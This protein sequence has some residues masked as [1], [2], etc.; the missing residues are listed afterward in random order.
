MRRRNYAE[1]SFV[2]STKATCA[3]TWE[4]HK[5]TPA[6]VKWGHMNTKTIIFYFESIYPQTFYLILNECR[7]FLPRFGNRMWKRSQSSNIRAGRVVA[8]DCNARLLR[9]AQDS[10]KR[11]IPVWSHCQFRGISPFHEKPF[12]H[13][14]DLLLTEREA[15][16]DAKNAR[17]DSA[18]R[19][20]EDPACQLTFI[21]DDTSW[22]PVTMHNRRG[23][24]KRKK[25]KEK[26]REVNSVQWYSKNTMLTHQT[27]HEFRHELR[28][29]SIKDCVLCNCC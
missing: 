29:S 19:E 20:N 27:R 16:F 5:R 3:L 24:R 2:S 26:K 28:R 8:V 14:M 15:H 12:I 1:H 11:T 25:G 6:S 7:Y 4:K 18:V 21:P 23:W 10:F 17:C 13:E 22:I 9:N